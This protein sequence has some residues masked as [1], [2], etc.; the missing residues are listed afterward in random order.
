MKEF[1]FASA[2]CLVGCSEVDADKSFISAGSADSK[3]TKTPM[4]FDEVNSTAEEKLRPII[5]AASNKGLYLSEK[6]E[7]VNSINSS[8]GRLYLGN[9]DCELEG[10]KVYLGSAELEY[11]VSDC[12]TGERKETNTYFAIGVSSKDEYYIVSNDEIRKPV[13]ICNKE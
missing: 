9:I 6:C 8:N 13:F 10:V 7:A 11:K 2:I 3:E 12:K 5:K 4:V 1:I